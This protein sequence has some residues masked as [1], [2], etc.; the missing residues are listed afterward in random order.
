MREKS[1]LGEIWK[2]WSYSRRVGQTCQK[3]RG[4]IKSYKNHLTSIGQA[5]TPGLWSLDASSKVKGGASLAWTSF[6]RLCHRLLV[7]MRFA[8]FRRLWNL[9]RTIPKQCLQCAM[10]NY[11]AEI[12]H[13]PQEKPLPLP[14]TLLPVQ[15]L[16]M[17]GPL[18]VGRNWQAT[19]LHLWWSDPVT[20]P[21]YAFLSSFMFYFVSQR[22]T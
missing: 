5:W 3:R 22:C 18:W 19:N 20:D 15:W 1:Q 7:K 8:I 21:C 4:P 12:G 11:P 13:F 17:L 2:T 16:P 14:I 9:C 6:S 10:V